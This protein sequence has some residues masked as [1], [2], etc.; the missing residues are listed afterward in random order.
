MPKNML[1]ISSGLI[2][3]AYIL[4]LLPPLLLMPT[5]CSEPNRS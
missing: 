1:K 5:G 3:S 2:S 4:C